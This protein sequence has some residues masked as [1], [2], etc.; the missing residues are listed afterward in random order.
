MITVICGLEFNNQNYV[1]FHNEDKNSELRML[2][3]NDKRRLTLPRKWKK[4]AVD[5]SSS[6]FIKCDGTKVFFG[7]NAFTIVKG[8][9]KGSKR[10]Y[11][12]VR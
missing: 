5:Q 10:Y 11:L 4:C 9:R 12:E 6:W 7:H 2:I 8:G 3:N 1:F